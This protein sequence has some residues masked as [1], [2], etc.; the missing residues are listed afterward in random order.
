VS[1]PGIVLQNALV[2]YLN[3]NTKVS[4]VSKVSNVSKA[5]HLALILSLAFLFWTLYAKSMDVMDKLNYL[6]LTL[7]NGKTIDPP[8]GVPRGGIT[9]LGKVLG[10]AVSM[11]MLAVIIATLFF[12]VFG[13][14]QW[15][16]SNGEKEKIAAARKKITWAL[17][18]LIVAL[19][20][21]FLINVLGGF[22]G[23]N[24]LNVK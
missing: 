13:A 19:L 15:T 4:R 12:I 21:Y 11:F 6:A 5:L 18:G 24:L 1:Y 9:Y 3:H 14:I 17:I 10:N 16:S 8:A 7:P 2:P 20:A 22:F 23:V